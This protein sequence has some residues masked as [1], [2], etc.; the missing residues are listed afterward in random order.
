MSIVDI[1]SMATLT[2]YSGGRYNLRA[3]WSA[4]TTVSSL[5]RPVDCRTLPA[6]NLS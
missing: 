4:K 2:T 6:W 3:V 1:G 5:P